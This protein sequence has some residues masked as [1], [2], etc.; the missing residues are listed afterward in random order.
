MKKKLFLSGLAV[1]SAMVLSFSMISCGDSSNDSTPPV[2]EPTPTPETTL[3]VSGLDAPFAADA[4]SMSQAQEMKITTNTA[5]GIEDKPDWLDIT[6]MTGNGD[7]T[8]KVWPNKTNTSSEDRTADITI[9]AG[10]K[11]VTKSITQRAGSSKART[12]PTNVLVMCYGVAMD[13]S[14]NS[15]VSYYD[16]AI[17][18]NT[19][20]VKYSD[21]ELAQY[22]K[23]S[24]ISDRKTPDDEWIISTTSLSTTETAGIDYTIVTV[25]YDNKGEQGEVVKIPFTTK[26]TANAPVV[27][28]D[29]LDLV[30]SNNSYYLIWDIVGNTYVNKYYTWTVLAKNKFLTFNKGDYLVAWWIH[31]EIKNNP[32]SHYTTINSNR[33]YSTSYE[34]LEGPQLKTGEQVG[35]APFN[36]ETNYI[37]IVSWGTDQNNNLSGDINNWTIDLTTS[38]APNRVSARRNPLKQNQNNGRIV[39]Q[40]ISKK[41]L[42]DNLS[43]LPVR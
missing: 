11:S 8:V 7:A 34:R 41:D 18:R 19:E 17:M 5:W 37:Q 1:F 33:G 10:D 42:D 36:V 29:N 22:L 38:S 40:G 12:T 43:I 39:Y 31:K 6:P 21:T 28:A 23:S 27:Y 32:N 9:K 4:N 14:C 26:P 13:F 15:Y 35:M 3:T 25:S 24:S 30:E 16:Y 2:P 20:V